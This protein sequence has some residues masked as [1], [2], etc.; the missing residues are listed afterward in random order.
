MALLLM[1]EPNST[2]A[3]MAV[4]D[5]KQAVL[6]KNMVANRWNSLR[7]EFPRWF[8]FPP[9]D[10]WKDL[11][12]QL[13]H[14]IK[15]RHESARKKISQVK[16]KLSSTKYFGIVIASSCATSASMLRGKSIEQ[17]FNNWAGG[18]TTLESVIEVLDACWETEKKDL[19][20]CFVNVKH[21][22]NIGYTE[23]PDCSK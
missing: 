21:G 18:H 11:P 16:S 3:A 8:E 9:Y 13:R 5:D 2:A 17:V 14:D 1:T 15:K 12:R 6:E 22:T 7:K 4:I 23:L 20:N 19:L 10:V